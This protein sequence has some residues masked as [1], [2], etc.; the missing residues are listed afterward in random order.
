MSDIEVYFIPKL[1]IDTSGSG[2][3]W[4]QLP[5]EALTEFGDK[6][7]DTFRMFICCHCG[8]HM[9]AYCRKVPK[10]IPEGHGA[11]FPQE[12]SQT[13]RWITQFSFETRTRCPKND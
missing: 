2:H 7:R 12:D 11:Y 4:H 6:Q 13:Y 5:P 8:G 3:C 10:P 1:E 9:H